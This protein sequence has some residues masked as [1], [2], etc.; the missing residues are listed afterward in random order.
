M[1]NRITLL[2]TVLLLLTAFFACGCGGAAQEP[3]STPE[4]TPIPTPE[5]T[6][7]PTPEPVMTPGD[8]ITV[9]GTLLE[10]GSFMWND[11][12]YMKLSRGGGSTGP[13]PARGGRKH[14]LPVVRRANQP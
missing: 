11:C 13:E 9:D 10:S 6:P 8:E 14:L 5:P 12:C 3:V 7:V 1:K 4:P 2:L